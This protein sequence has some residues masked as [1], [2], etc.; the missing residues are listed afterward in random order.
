MKQN[1]NSSVMTYFKDLFWYR[2]HEEY[3]FTI[4]EANNDENASYNENNNNYKSPKNIFPHVNVN[5][6]VITTRYNT[7]IN[8]DVVIR[9]FSLIAKNREYKAFILYIDGMVDTKIINDFVLDPL[10][11]RNRSNTYENSEDDVVREVV[12]NNIVVRKVK[13]FDLGTYILNHLI[14]QNSVKQVDTFDDVASSVNSG[15]CLLFVDTLNI[16][17]DIDA[18]GFKQRSVG[19]PENEIVIRGS[20]E[21][22]TE[23]IRTNTSLLRRFCNNE[24]LIIENLEVGNLTKTK[25]AIC[26]MKNIAN[27]DLIAEVKYR[28]NNISVDSIISSGQL[29]QLI[30]DNG[31]FSIP[32]MVSTERPDNATNFLLSGRV[33]ILVNGSPYALIAPGTFID[34][35]ASPEDLNLKY[36]F[37]NLLKL[38]RILA[39][40]LT[41]LLPGFYVAVTNF[42]QE[43]LPTELLFAIVASRENIPLPIIFEILVMEISFELIR[44]AGI[45]VPSPLGPT[46]GI[47]GALILGQAAVDANIVSPILIIVVAIT[48]I[49]SFAIPDYSFSFHFRLARFI[50]IISGYLLGFLGIATCLFFHFLLLVSLSSFGYPYLQPY[51]PVTKNYNGL[52]LSPVWK[53]EHRADFLNT[54]RPKEQP[55]I[56]MKWKYPNK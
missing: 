6:E 50:Y 26:Y 1:K 40:L 53:R 41:L 22:F 54:K 28:I 29:E 14:P 32:Q 21:G 33:V 4:P 46:I 7:M 15:N 20:Q 48:A 8:S 17:F 36:K 19:K 5:L 43:L 27:N 56:S 45:R 18:K 2:P 38:V 24:K 52:L 34:F 25:C 30:S 3:S 16:A 37:S 39:I 9:E 23:N 13:K 31:K 12:A 47:V 51:V 44:E 55:N 42:H 49:A 11:L 10:M 35:I